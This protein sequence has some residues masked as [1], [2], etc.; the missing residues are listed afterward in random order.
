MK[1]IDI[2][3]LI[4]VLRLVIRGLVLCSSVSTPRVSPTSNKTKKILLSAFSSATREVQLNVLIADDNQLCRNAVVRLMEK[5]SSSIT[6][7]DDGQKAYDALIKQ[8]DQPF[9][10]LITDNQMPY[11]TGLE[12]ITTIRERE[13]LTCITQSLQILCKK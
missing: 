8:A 4:D 12:L 7:C 10:F 1:P 5:H 11:K 9:N 13:K 2:N 3:Y 6:V